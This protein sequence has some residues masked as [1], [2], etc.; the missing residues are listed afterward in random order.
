MSIMPLA[1]ISLI[2][3]PGQRSSAAQEVGVDEERRAEA[4][5]LEDR[6]GDVVGRAEPVIHRYHDRARR[7][8]TRSLQET[9]QIGERDDVVVVVLQV[10]HLRDE[11][12]ARHDHAVGRTSVGELVVAKDRHGLIAVREH[13]RFVERLERHDDQAAGRRRFGAVRIGDEIGER[14]ILQEALRQCGVCLPAPYTDDHEVFG[15]GDDDGF[16]RARRRCDEEAVRRAEAPQ[17]SSA[18]AAASCNRPRA[19]TEHMPQCFS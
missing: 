11:E 19:A 18:A 17:R 15:S 2:A 5:G 13:A 12:V 4:V 1:R 14:R 3:C 16:F 9:F 10:L 8:R 6:I 7:Y